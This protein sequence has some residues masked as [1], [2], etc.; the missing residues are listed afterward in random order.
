MTTLIAE[1]PM[2][3]WIGTG[4]K[5]SKGIYHCT[6]DGQSGRLS[7]SRLVAEM[8]A[9][10]FLAMHPKLP[11]LYAVGSVSGQSV[12]AAFRITGSGDDAALVLASSQPIGDGGATHVA[13]SPDGG[14]LLTA[15]YGGGSVAAFSVAADGNVVARTSLIE[16]EGG[17]NAF[18]NRQTSPHPH[19]VGFSP[20]QK[21]AFVP[22]LGLDQVVIYRV[23]T[24]KATLDPH[25]AGMLSP[26]AGPRHQRFH[27]NGKWIYVLNELDLTVSLFDWSAKAGT[28]ELRETVP[29]VAKQELDRLQQKSCSEIRI[30][31]NGRFVYAANRGHD[32]ITVFAVAEDGTLSEIQNE[33]VRGATPRNFNLAP[34][35]RWLLAAGQ[36]SHTLA[37]F[38][39]DSESGLLTYNHN[40][41]S[42]PS[43]IC[44]LLESE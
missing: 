32:T 30:H 33:P 26:G 20:D 27:P 25:G 16:H 18:P 44:V 23:N 1:E 41:I 34:S 2:D 12:V 3:V 17:S 4:G 40:V 15:Q 8:D 29:T 24:Q 28:M 35:G 38:G 9:P 6:L 43:P 31:P 19:W 36:D 10:G 37:C 5:P 21:F 7:E 13:I 39:V 42:T 14:M 11:M 22:D